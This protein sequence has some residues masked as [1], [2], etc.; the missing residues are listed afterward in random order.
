[1]TD[2]LLN[3]DLE[4]SKEEGLNL[5]GHSYF[6]G[7]RTGYLFEISETTHPHTQLRE[8]EVSLEMT[9]TLPSDT[10]LCFSS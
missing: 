2:M 5:W 10:S 1:M 6:Q 3:S 4:S 7:L 8:K 9:S